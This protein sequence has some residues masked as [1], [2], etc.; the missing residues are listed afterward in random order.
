MNQKSLAILV[1]H[2]RVLKGLTVFFLIY[3]IVYFILDFS[4][5]K[6]YLRFINP[7]LLMIIILPSFYWRIRKVLRILKDEEQLQASNESPNE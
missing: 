4:H 5:N 1:N 7:P 3:V 6:T 2:V